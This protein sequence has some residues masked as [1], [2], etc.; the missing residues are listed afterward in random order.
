MTS[1]KYKRALNDIQELINFRFRTAYM[2][3][4][5]KEYDKIIEDIEK[6]IKEVLK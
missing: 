5:F 4:G 1:E 3:F 2:T 6:I